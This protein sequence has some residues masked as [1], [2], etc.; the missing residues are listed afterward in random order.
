MSPLPY[1][2]SGEMDL[3]MELH[4][5]NFTLTSIQYYAIL[6]NLM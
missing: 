6:V 5:H 4:L 3:K 1:T 2:H